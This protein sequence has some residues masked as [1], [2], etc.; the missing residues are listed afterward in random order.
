MAWGA[1]LGAA[2]AAAGAEADVEEEGTSGHSVCRCMA[3][4]QLQLQHKS[5]E[6]TT[7]N[8]KGVT[9]TNLRDI[10][11][12]V[13]LEWVEIILDIHRRAFLDGPSPEERVGRLYM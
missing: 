6:A 13:V 11:H 8:I 5:I 2:Y 10:D 12:L 9:L 1:A 7:E 4:L 3:I